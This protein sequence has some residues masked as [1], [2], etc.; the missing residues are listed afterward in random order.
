MFVHKAHFTIKPQISW[1]VK[2]IKGLIKIIIQTQKK[3]YNS[4]KPTKLDAPN[5]LLANL[6]I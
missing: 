2:N 5:I 6:Y 3:I 1:H 4:H